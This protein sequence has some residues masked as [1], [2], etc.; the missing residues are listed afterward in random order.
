V[1]TSVRTSQEAR[2]YTVWALPVRTSQE[3][4]R[5]TV[6]A[7]PVR[8]SQEARRYTVWAE[9]RFTYA[10]ALGTIGCH[11]SKWMKPSL[12]A[13]NCLTS[14]HTRGSHRNTVRGDFCCY[15][16][17]RGGGGAGALEGIVPLRKPDA[18][19]ISSHSKVAVSQRHSVTVTLICE[20][21]PQVTTRLTDNDTGLRG[22]IVTGPE[23]FRAVTGNLEVS[24][25]WHRVAPTVGG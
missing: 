8:T 10:K 22:S 17:N 5:Y 24:W 11:C 9:C 23:M 13:R 21:L 19:S 20:T 1:G 2:R 14:R 7:L 6:W 3:A 4:R 15:V 18:E 16:T 25:L 12:L